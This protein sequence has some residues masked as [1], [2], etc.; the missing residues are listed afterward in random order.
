MKEYGV[1]YA[2]VNFPNGHKYEWL[3]HCFLTKMLPIELQSEIN[4]LSKEINEKYKD[5]II[6]PMDSNINPGCV[7][8]KESVEEI[9]KS[10]YNGL[11]DIYKRLTGDENCI[12]LVYGVGDMDQYNIENLYKSTHEVGYYPIIVKVGRYLDGLKEPGIYT[13]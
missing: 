11:F 4:N 5:D 6:I 1:L 10:I 7:T 12:I 2:K 9:A 3:R 13:V 8:T